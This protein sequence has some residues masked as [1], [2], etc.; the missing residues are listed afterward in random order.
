M[1]SIGTRNRSGTLR[2]RCCCCKRT[3][4]STGMSLHHCHDDAKANGLVDAHLLGGL[5]EPQDRLFVAIGGV[6]R[7]VGNGFGLAAAAVEKINL[8]VLDSDKMNR[9]KGQAYGNT[10]ISQI[11]KQ[12]GRTLRDNRG[13]IGSFRCVVFGYRTLL[14]VVV[15]F[16]VAVNRRPN[17]SCVVVVV[18]VVCAAAVR[19]DRNPAAFVNDNESTEQILQHGATVV[20]VVFVRCRSAFRCRSVVRIGGSSSSSSS[21]SIV[22]VVVV[23]DIVVVV[24]NVDFLLLLPL[25]LPES[26]FFSISAKPKPTATIIA[27]RTRRQRGMHYR[28]GN[29]RTCSLFVHRRCGV[30]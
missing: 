15:W 11:S 24:V 8:G 9:R 18:V 1:A 26:K 16:I 20:V 4:T 13:E 3:S 5:F 6:D 21:T 19:L 23:R 22:F 10:A 25:L 28:S 30:V 29:H 14:G 17:T 2:H 7:G 27:G 12:Q